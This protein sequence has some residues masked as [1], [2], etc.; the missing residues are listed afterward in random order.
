LVAVVMVSSAVAARSSSGAIVV[1]SKNFTE[2]L[3][4]ENWSRKRLSVPA[5][6]WI[7]N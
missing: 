3:I 4:R 7:A 6:A 2:Q 5:S 1:G